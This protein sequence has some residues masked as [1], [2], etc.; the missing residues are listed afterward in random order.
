MHKLVAAAVLTCAGC[1]VLSSEGWGGAAGGSSYTTDSGTV[2][3]GV[4]CLTREGKP[5]LVI[6]TA[7]G[8]PTHVSGGPPGSGSIKAA[9]GRDVEWSCSTRDG[10]TGKL[11][12][13]GSPFRLED[14]EV[15]LV[16]LHAGRIVVEQVSVDMSQL[17]GAFVEDRLKAL[18]TTD[19]RIARFLQVCES[20]K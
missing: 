3:R 5:Y 20:P 13:G 7:D 12:I 16:N 8:E 1:A 4:A 11:V 2:H 19:T 18:A 9:D 6:L 10:V 15:V 17:E 14:G